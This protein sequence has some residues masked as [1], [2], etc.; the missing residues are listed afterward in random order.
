[1]NQKLNGGQWNLLGTYYFDIGV[2]SVV[3]S[4]Y[5]NGFI[6][7]DAVKFRVRGLIMLL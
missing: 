1:M 5:A 4:D 3:L 7:A 2:Y 6:M